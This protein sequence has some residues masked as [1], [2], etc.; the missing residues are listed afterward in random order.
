MSSWILDQIHDSNWQIIFTM[1][2]INPFSIQL[3]SGSIWFVYQFHFPAF[4]SNQS[5]CST[6]SEKEIKKDKCLLFWGNAL[7][8]WWF[9]MFADVRE[10]YCVRITRLVESHWLWTKRLKLSQK[11]VAFF[12]TFRHRSPF[13]CYKLSGILWWVIR[14]RYLFYS[15][16]DT[17]IEEQ[18]YNWK[19]IP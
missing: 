13:W 14:G 19:R 1:L 8:R 2:N 15:A 12:D 9:F 17:N 4:I 5:D 3:L 7:A 11:N 6:I 16:A 10:C 18:C